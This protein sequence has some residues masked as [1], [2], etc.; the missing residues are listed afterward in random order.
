[1]EKIK[2][3][4]QWC[5]VP[6]SADPKHQGI[7]HPIF[8]LVCGCFFNLLASYTICKILM[9]SE[10]F[11]KG[12]LSP[13]ATKYLSKFLVLYI[14]FMASARFYAMGFYFHQKKLKMT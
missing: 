2:E 14:I 11:R 10:K 4:L 6:D 7:Y 12:T 8:A 3:I 9:R 1:M 13:W 5:F